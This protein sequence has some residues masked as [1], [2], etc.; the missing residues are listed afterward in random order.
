[1]TIERR[2]F[3]EPASL[4]AT[5]LLCCN[6]VQHV[7]GLLINETNSISMTA[8]W[9]SKHRSNSS[10]VRHQQ[11][12]GRWRLH[13]GLRL[14][15]YKRSRNWWIVVQC[16]AGLLLVGSRI[17]PSLFAFSS[18]PFLNPSPR[19]GLLRLIVSL[20]TSMNKEWLLTRPI[21]LTTKGIYSTQLG[22]V[23]G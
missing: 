11:S 23:N 5:E 17:R 10:S 2:Q 12:G 6:T 14:Q 13:S 21:A 19:L 22:F 4:C 1:M 16:T 15:S 8:G 7:G 3:G 9:R 20:L 18:V